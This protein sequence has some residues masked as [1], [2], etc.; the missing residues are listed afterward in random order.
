MKQNAMTL[1]G[2]DLVTDGMT[3]FKVAQSG[4]QKTVGALMVGVGIGLRT[5]GTIHSVAQPVVAQA[6]VAATRVG[7]EKGVISPRV[8]P[9]VA[10]VLTFIGTMAVTSIAISAA[11][12]LATKAVAVAALS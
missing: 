3:E 10:G 2:R 12:P 11:V 6:A 5:V 1:A 7:V 8:S 9:K 4:A